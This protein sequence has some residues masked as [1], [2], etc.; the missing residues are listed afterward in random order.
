MKFLLVVFAVLT[1]SAAAHAGEPTEV[2]R[3]FYESIGLEREA[4]VRDLFIDPAR[5]VLDAN[6][7]L[8]E[9][10][11]GSCLDVGLS[12]DGQDYD[13]AEIKRTLKFAEKIDGD[14]ARVIANFQVFSEPRHIEWKLK[15]VDG[16]WKIA[17]IASLT[18]E[19]A[20]SSFNC[21]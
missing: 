7:K 6:D 17:D 20:L 15:R 3:P 4:S 9:T 2:V 16:Q 8:E 21:E 1:L 11:S 19:W 14:S 5:A 12:V 13:E 10:E 18:N